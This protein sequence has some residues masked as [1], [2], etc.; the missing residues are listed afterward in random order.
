MARQGA[1][2]VLALE[3]EARAHRQLVNIGE[4]LKT[5][6][7]AGQMPDDDEMS[8]LQ[9]AYCAFIEAGRSVRTAVYQEQVVAARRRR[10]AA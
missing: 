4:E 5:V 7:M 1:R 2:L 9:Q 10:F 8:R 6:Y 3:A